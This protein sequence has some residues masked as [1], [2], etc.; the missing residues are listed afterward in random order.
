[1]AVWVFERGYASPCAMLC[2]PCL[3]QVLDSPGVRPMHRQDGQQRRDPPVVD[4]IVRQVDLLWERS[5]CD[6][7]D[8]SISA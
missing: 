8:P 2:V 1:M 5:G 6:K 3:L 4:L 7:T